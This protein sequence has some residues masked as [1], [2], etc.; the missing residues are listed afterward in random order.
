MAIK[1]RMLL[2]SVVVLSMMWLVGCSGH[3][4]CGTTFGGTCSTGT[5]TTTSPS[6]A[7]AFA[8]VVDENGTMDGYAL[9]TTAANIWRCFKPTPRRPSR[10]I[11]VALEWWS[12]RGRYLYAGVGGCSTNLRVVDR[13]QWKFDC[14]DWLSSSLPS[15]SGISALTYNQD[16]VITILQVRT[17]LFI[18]EAV[19]EQILVLSD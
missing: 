9:N 5:T 1:V 12:H 11:G 14:I 19:N 17:L 16:V 3:Y 2:S 18:S 13:Q 8:Y 10:P 6:T 7:N 15:L 4:H